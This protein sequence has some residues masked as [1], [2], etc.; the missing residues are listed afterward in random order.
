MIISDLQY[1]E[2]IDELNQAEL[3]GGVALGLSLGD[4][5]AA[6]VNAAV[7]ITVNNSQ[8]FDGGIFGSIATANG[9]SL[10]YAN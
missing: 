1:L 7:A 5:A 9:L 2:N 10:S 4:A 8:A 6:G 3:E